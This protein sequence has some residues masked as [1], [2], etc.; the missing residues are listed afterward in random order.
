MADERD[1]ELLD[2]YITNRL[3]EADRA[4]FEQKLHADPDLQ[5]EYALQQRLVEGI[6]HARAAELKS[7]LNRVSIPSNNPGN[8]LVTKVIL[9]T[10]ASLIIAAGGYWY[11]SAEDNDVVK[12]DTVTTR[13]ER[14]AEKPAVAQPEA[15]VSPKQQKPAVIQKPKIEGDKNQTSAGTEH[16]KP[17]LAKK[18]DPLK[19]PGEKQEGQNAA[20]GPVFDVFDPTTE[21][22]A[23]DND[24]TGDKNTVDGPTK[25]SLIV[26]TDRFNGQYTFHY[27]FRDGKLLL[28]GPFEK[29]L[30]E[31]ME[32]AAKEKRT[33]FLYYKDRY[34]LLEEADANVRPLEPITDPALLQKLKEYRNSK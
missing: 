12:P 21:D 29:N 34:Y 27:Q 31:I 5:H 6:K 20:D 32:F 15:K 11:F 18:P 7:M 13:Q 25:S 22:P 10:V 30:Y 16:S 4:A 33:V 14:K 1:F 23:R 26:E 3:S 8:S 24:V 19:A 17:S 9:G 2:D 28:F